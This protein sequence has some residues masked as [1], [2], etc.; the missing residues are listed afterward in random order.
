MSETECPRCNETFHDM[1]DD[2]RFRSGEFTEELPDGTE[3]VYERLCEDCH[4]AVARS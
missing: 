1:Y 3:V 2:E 4:R